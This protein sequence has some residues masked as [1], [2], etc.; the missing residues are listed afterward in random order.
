[1]AHS[2]PHPLSSPKLGRG[3]KIISL[4]DSNGKVKA[5]GETRLNLVVFIHIH[6]SHL[7][8]FEHMVGTRHAVSAKI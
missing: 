1:M 8:G 2:K 3:G 6:A 5:F 4:P 7:W